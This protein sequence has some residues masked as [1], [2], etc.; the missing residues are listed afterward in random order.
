[1]QQISGKDLFVLLTVMPGAALGLL[2]P[3]GVVP[4]IT[5]FVDNAHSG[6]RFAKPNLFQSWPVWPLGVVGSVWVLGRLRRIGSTGMIWKV[7]LCATLLSSALVA[8]FGFSYYPAYL[9]V[10]ADSAARIGADLREIPQQAEVVVCEG[11][12]GWFGD[13]PNVTVIMSNPVRVPL[14]G[15]E[16]YFVLSPHVG[17]EPTA[18]TESVLDVVRSELH[19]SVVSHRHGVWVLRWTPPPGQRSFVLRAHVPDFSLT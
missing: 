7:F 10:P 1:M 15:G 16:V 13:R 18:D 8:V 6:I 5:L 2:S 17:G 9:N 3:F 19:A 12:A 14:P 4:L 11:I